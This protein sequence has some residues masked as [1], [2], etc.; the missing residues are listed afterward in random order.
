M[1]TAATAFRADEALRPAMTRTARDKAAIALLAFFV[2]IGFTIEAYWVVHND[3]MQGR[4]DVVA[5]LLAL[6]WPA[7]RNYRVPGRD[8]AKSFTLAL[9][10][11]NA[12]VTQWL[13]LVLIWAIARG[14]RWRHVLQLVVATYTFYG[15]VLYYYVAHLS[16]YAVLAYRGTYP[17]VMFYA[18]NAPWLLGCGWLMWDAVDAIL[19]QRSSPPARA[20]GG[21]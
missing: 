6:Y 3:S 15:T 13:N 11:I 1:A 9:E 20:T 12:F 5:R 19:R 4:H 10:S 21:K 17:F 7:D 18:A 16:G 14:R 8:V 2:V